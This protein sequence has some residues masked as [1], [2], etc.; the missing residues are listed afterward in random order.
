MSG[1]EGHAQSLAG[2]QTEALIRAH[3]FNVPVFDC[4]YHAF[5][6]PRNWFCSMFDLELV[7]KD[8]RYMGR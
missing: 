7:A 2:V 5:I 4:C 6:Y 1:H 3:F 8:I